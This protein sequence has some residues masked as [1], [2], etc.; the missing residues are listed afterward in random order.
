MK[1]HG[2]SDDWTYVVYRLP[3]VRFY[4]KWNKKT[5]K[6][7]ARVLNLIRIKIKPITIIMNLQYLID[8]QQSRANWS[9]FER[10]QFFSTNTGPVCYLNERPPIRRLIFFLTPKKNLFERFLQWS[11]ICA[12]N[13]SSLD[14]LEKYRWGATMK[15]QLDV[16]FH[17]LRRWIS[18]K[19]LWH[20]LC[21]LS[22]S[23]CNQCALLRNW[24]CQHALPQNLENIRCLQQEIHV[25]CNGKR[26]TMFLSS[27]KVKRT[28]YY[29]VLYL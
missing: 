3:R 6:T 23:I 8:E 22:K 12:S 25:A 7:I 14:T 1:R 15:C 11:P 17:I 24:S 5:Q 21:D 9:I 4:N 13:I 29:K 26:Q 18:T 19:N 2:N 16:L 28:L 20:Q 10:Q 27:F